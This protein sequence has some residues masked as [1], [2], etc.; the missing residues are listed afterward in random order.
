ML[1]KNESTINGYFTSLDWKIGT[2]CNIKMF[3]GFVKFT[4]FLDWYFK[5]FWHMFHVNKNQFKSAMKKYKGAHIT[6]IFR[7]HK[8]IDFWVHTFI[9]TTCCITA[10]STYTTCT[11]TYVRVCSNIVN[12]CNH[13]IPVGQIF[14]LFAYTRNF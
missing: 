8:T 3:N 13:R 2:T 9:F 7:R 4:Q 11:C 5:G 6:F 12:N 10:K 14:L 1:K